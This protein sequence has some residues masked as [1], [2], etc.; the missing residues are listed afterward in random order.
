MHSDSLNISTRPFYI[1]TM[2]FFSNS[3]S[4]LLINI[5][6]KYFDLLYWYKRVL[7]VV[8]Q[9]LILTGISGKSGGGWWLF[10]L[11]IIFHPLG[12][13]LVDKGCI[14]PSAIIIIIYHI[15]V[16]TF[17]ECSSLCSLN[18]VCGWTRC[19][20][21]LCGSTTVS[22]WRRT[23]RAPKCSWWTPIPRIESQRPAAWWTLTGDRSKTV[24]SKS[25]A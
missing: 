21:S 23:C 20:W 4:R 14:D 18:G 7:Y 11:V 1:L 3:D 19:W 25:P 8:I 5:N 13:A 9:T 17:T 16:V 22:H 10:N 2:H 15:I 24:W 12:S 6:I